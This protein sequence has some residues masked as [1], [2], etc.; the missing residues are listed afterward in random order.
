LSLFVSSCSCINFTAFSSNDYLF[1]E[2]TITDCYKSSSIS[3]LNLFPLSHYLFVL[4]VWW[5]NS[6]NRWLFEMFYSLDFGNASLSHS[7][8]LLL[9]VFLLSFANISRS[10]F[11]FISLLWLKNAL[12]HDT[13][14]V[15]VYNGTISKFYSKSYRKNLI[16]Y[17]IK[18][19]WIWN[20]LVS[21]CSELRKS[22]N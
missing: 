18:L 14:K 11:G 19:I 20:L 4:I 16:Y 13:L 2:L 6:S 21:K 1:E 22:N 15:L 7:F 3:S 12:V 10:L 8:V 5:V 9:V 17:K